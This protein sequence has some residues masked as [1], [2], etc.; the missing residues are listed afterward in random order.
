MADTAWEQISSFLAPGEV[1]PV[2]ALSLT[3]DLSFLLW[4]SSS[5]TLSCIFATDAS[6]LPSSF[7]P[8]WEKLQWCPRVQTTCSAL[9]TS[10]QNQHL[11]FIS[12]PC[13]S[14]TPNLNQSCLVQN[15]YQLS[16]GK[17]SRKKSHLPPD[18]A[19]RKKVKDESSEHSTGVLK[20]TKE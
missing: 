15:I 1:I 7:S 6:S 8:F 12:S 3:S 2:P 17:K 18:T 10:F 16:T 4:W 20:L 19:G 5:A 9:D 14:S 13:P 11:Q